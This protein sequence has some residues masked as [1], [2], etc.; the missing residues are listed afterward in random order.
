LWS[1]RRFMIHH[2]WAAHGI[3]I[4]ANRSTQHNSLV[5]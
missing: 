3:A 2:H 1:C 5:D 4:W